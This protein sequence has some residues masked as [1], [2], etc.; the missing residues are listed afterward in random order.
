MRLPTCA[1][2][3]FLC[4]R[5]TVLMVSTFAVSGGS[6]GLANADELVVPGALEFVEGN[7]ANC[8]PLTGC[9]QHRRYQQVFASSEFGALTTP[10]LITEIRFRPDGGAAPLTNTS[11]ANMQIRM[12]TTDK[13]P[14]SNQPP[15]PSTVP[16]ELSAT[17]A[18]NVGDDEAIVVTSRTV[19][20]S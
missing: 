4:F 17:F 20:G 11:F 3:R 6:V 5:K 16:S 14:P 1:V 2:S 8:F 10:A 7:I 18:D 12:S 13:Q 15:G 9:G 19:S